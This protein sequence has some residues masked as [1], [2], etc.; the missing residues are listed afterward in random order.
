MKRLTLA[1][2]LALAACAGTP[3]PTW[4]DAMLVCAQRGFVAGVE[5]R[6]CAQAQLQHW[7]AQDAAR[8]A[9][10]LEYVGTLNR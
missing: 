3:E 10:L 9:A 2:A 4:D 6:Q 1:G 5:R 8:D 7:Q